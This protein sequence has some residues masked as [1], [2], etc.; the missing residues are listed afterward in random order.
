MY[1][2]SSAMAVQFAA[3][4]KEM[5]EQIAELGANPLKAKDEADVP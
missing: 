3:A 1:N 5:S 2:M 4:A